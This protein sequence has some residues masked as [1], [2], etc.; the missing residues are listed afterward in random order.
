[1]YTPMDMTKR[2]AAPAPT[3][4]SIA[5][6]RANLPA[7]VRRAA[8]GEEIQITRR[9]IPIALLRSLPNA[10]DERAGRLRALVAEMVSD[11]VL[12]EDDTDPWADVR[13]RD[14]GRPP[15][16]FRK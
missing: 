9:G 6:A 11:Q 8:E 3:S 16:A 12:R 10:E 15:P 7:V 14:P 13:D 1:M 5:D 4:L 2:R